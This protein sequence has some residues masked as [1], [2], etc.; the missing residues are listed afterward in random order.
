MLSDTALSSCRAVF[1]WLA[2]C[3]HVLVL[4]GAGVSV[5]SGLPVYR[6]SEDS[7]YSDPRRLRLGQKV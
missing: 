2:D 5:A 7:V 6:G 1:K 4:T 3:R